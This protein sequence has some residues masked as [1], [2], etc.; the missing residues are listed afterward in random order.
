[1]NLRSFLFLIL[2]FPA[3]NCSSPKNEETYK[4]D[5]SDVSSADS[6]KILLESNAS[7]ETA[8]DEPSDYNKRYEIY[9]T[10][11]DLLNE[12]NFELADKLIRENKVDLNEVHSVVYCSTT[13]L[14]DFSSQKEVVEFLLSNGADPNSSS[15]ISCEEG[16]TIGYTTTCDEI[17]AE[18]LIEAG[19]NYALDHLVECVGRDGDTQK[20]KALVARGANKD[21]ALYWVVENEEIE[22]ARELVQSKARINRESSVAFS[23]NEELKKLIINVIDGNIYTWLRGGEGFCDGSTFINTAR[24]GNRAALLFMLEAGADPNIFCWQ[25]DDDDLQCGSRSALGAAKGNGNWEIVG[26][27]ERYGATEPNECL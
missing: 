7:A 17:I 22:L 14:F 15:F 20:I 10:L 24:D 27:L 25:D 18:L 1:M 26:L 16:E 5:T 11:K 23:S 12:M 21:E 19:S 4:I 6:I 9:N 2:I 13:L 8:R 3:L